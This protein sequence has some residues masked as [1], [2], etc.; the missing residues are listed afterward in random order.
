MVIWIT[1]ISGAG[2]TTICETIVGMT[3]PSVPE[4]VLLDGDV[5]RMFSE[6]NS[7]L[8]KLIEFAKSSA[9]RGLVKS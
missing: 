9:F 3:K 2:K 7:A 8:P 4:L 6:M 5:V 1:G